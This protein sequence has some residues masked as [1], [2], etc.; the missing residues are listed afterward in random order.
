L[1]REI[2]RAELSCGD[3]PRYIRALKT[4]ESQSLESA[5]DQEVDIA[6]IIKPLLAKGCI[7]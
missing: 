3:W 5:E 6:N 4:L 2:D 1:R 7:G